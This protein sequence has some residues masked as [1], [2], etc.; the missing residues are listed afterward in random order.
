MPDYRH[1]LQFGV[2]IPPA[3]GQADAVLELARLADEERELVEPLAR[4]GFY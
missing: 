1:D 2:C 3:A 4:Y